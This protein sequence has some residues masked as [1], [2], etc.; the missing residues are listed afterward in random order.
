MEE[1]LY[2][3]PAK[4]GKGIK[5][6]KE[7]TEKKDKD[8]KDHRT[9]NLILFLIFI[10]TVVL[11]ILWLLRGKTTTAGQYPA[12]VKNETL[13]CESSNLPYSKITS[14]SSEQKNLKLNL[15]FDNSE[16]L[17]SIALIYTMGFTNDEEVKR[18][19]AFAHAEFNLG[20]NAAGFNSSMFE[21]KFARYSN[22]LI[23]SLFGDL[24]TLNEYTASYFMIDDAESPDSLPKSI[25]EYAQNYQT[26]GFTCNTQ[27]K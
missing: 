3:K 26:Q 12:N 2:F 24:S 18:A 6:Q 16:K 8:E 4:Y 14:V 13:N 1:K 27:E 10:I 15:V 25:D 20:L 22:Q 11:I 23:I 9:R 5:N 7:K 19:E 21:N 17:K